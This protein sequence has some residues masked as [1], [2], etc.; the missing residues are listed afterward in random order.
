MQELL[1][2]ANISSTLQSFESSEGVLS[3]RDTL[4]SDAS[5]GLLWLLVCMCVC[6]CVCVCV[7][8]CVCVQVSLKGARI[9]YLAMYSS[10]AKVV[11]C[12]VGTFTFK[13]TTILNPS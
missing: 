3:L 8:M 4:V 6:V 10:N 2:N 13:S 1:S 12:E 9:Y 7:C 11:L 5:L